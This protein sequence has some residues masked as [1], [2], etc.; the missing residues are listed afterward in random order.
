MKLFFD[1]KEGVFFCKAGYGEKGIVRS[2]GFEWNPYFARWLTSDVKKA[3]RLK[4]YAVG[5]AREVIELW[6]RR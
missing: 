3:M 5:S 6:E 2:A 4:E 1:E